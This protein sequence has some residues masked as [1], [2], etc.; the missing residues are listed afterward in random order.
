MK[1]TIDEK[2]KVMVIEMPLLEAKPSASGK[3]MV[4]AT[5]GGGKPSEATFSGKPVI[6]NVTAYFKP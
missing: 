2:K 4:I 1:V 6:L 5:T 3:T